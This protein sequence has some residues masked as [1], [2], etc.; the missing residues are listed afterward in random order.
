MSDL[1]FTLN[2][3][4]CRSTIVQLLILSVATQSA[5]AAWMIRYYSKDEQENAKNFLQFLAERDQV[6]KDMLEGLYVEK[7]DLNLDELFPK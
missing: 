1:K 6:S 5:M 3:E 2:P 4:H 7:A